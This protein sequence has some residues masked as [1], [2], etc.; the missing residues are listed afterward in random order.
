MASSAETLAA[1]AGDLKTVYGQE[2][3]QVLPDAAILQKKFPLAS[4]A[5]YPNVG[6]FYSALIGLQ[7]PWGFSFLGTGYEGTT[8][9]TALG[10]ALAGQT[11]PAEIYACTTVLCENI[12]YQVLDRASGNNSTQ[13]VLSALTYTGEQMAINTRNVLELQILHGREGIG[14]ASGSVSGSGP[15]TVVFDPA[16]TSAGIL[17]TLIGA[18]VQWM[19]SDNTTARTAN[20]GSN[21]LTV[22]AVGL[23]DVNNP[24]I[25]MVATGTTTVGSIVTGDLM[26]IAGMRGV[27]VAAGATAVP[28]YE[29]IGLGLQIGAQTG[30][31]FSIDKALYPGWLG[32]S[33]PSVGQFSPSVLMSGAT[34]SLARGGEKGEYMAV[35]SPRQWG[36]LNSALATNEF[37]NQQAPS[38][39]MSKKSGTNDIEISQSGIT[40]TVTGHPFQKDGQ[41]YVFPVN[42]VKRI[43]S[44][45]LSFAIP[46]RPADEF[47][48]PLPGTATV[49]R[50]CR[51][52]WQIALLKPPSATKIS[53]VTY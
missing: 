30:S 48:Y 28:Q 49:Q 24:S 4:S 16:T 17:S 52:D 8:T 50:Q 20:D 5:A 38:F 44:V 41:A 32:N 22:S 23:S 13:S 47:L 35:V 37:Y 12:T 36:V 7:Y 46:G 10:D 27:T 21:Y 29:M 53:G 6:K 11:L 45:D 15:Y 9:N 1:I 34:A 3:I 33:L 19:Q 51:A 26:Y 2:L 40:M 31:Y 42:Q 18:R 43:G 14:A 39:S 25:T